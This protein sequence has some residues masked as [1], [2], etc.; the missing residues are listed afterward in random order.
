MSSAYSQLKCV[1][2]RQTDRQTERQK[3]D[4][5]VISI[6]EGLRRNSLKCQIAEENSVTYF[7]TNLICN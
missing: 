7:V 1:T 2:D 4:Q 3:M 5:N 6:V